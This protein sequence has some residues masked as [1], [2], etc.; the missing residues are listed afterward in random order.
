[1][2]GAPLLVDTVFTIL[3]QRKR[4]ISNPM[5]EFIEQHTKC[6]DVVLYTYHLEEI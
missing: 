1:M 6:A 2:G 4:N 3:S 5:F